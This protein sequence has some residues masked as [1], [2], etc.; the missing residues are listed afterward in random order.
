MMNEMK[1]NIRSFQTAMAENIH[2]ILFESQERLENVNQ[3]TFDFQVGVTSREVREAFMKGKTNYS[4]HLAGDE[5]SLFSVPVTT[6]RSKQDC[7]DFSSHMLYMPATTLLEEIS[8]SMANAGFTQKTRKR[9]QR[10]EI[11]A[12][13]AELDMFA[14]SFVSFKQD[15]L[16]GFLSH[17]YASTDNQ[18][19]FGTYISLSK[20][21]NHHESTNNHNS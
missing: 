18:C 8:R 1:L 3:E 2:T 20:G 4:L 12:V 14:D 15:I 17:K 11:K 19:L 10:H 13:D 21:L 7:P 5:E 16:F 9:K 6:I